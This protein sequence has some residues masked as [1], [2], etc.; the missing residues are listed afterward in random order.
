MKTEEINF[1]ILHKRKEKK[2]LKTDRHEGMRAS[3]KCTQ[4]QTALK[5][6]QRMWCSF[7]SFCLKK[8]QL[9]MIT[10]GGNVT[11]VFFFFFSS[12]HE[13]L[14]NVCRH[15]GASEPRANTSAKR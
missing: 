5:A 11:S 12:I 8:G 7:L 2:A 10:G 15:S 14:G 3:R 6:A 9:L 13:A 4:T 1:L